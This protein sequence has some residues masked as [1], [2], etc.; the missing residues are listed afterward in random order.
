VKK[1]NIKTVED[2]WKG[3]HELSGKRRRGSGEMKE[4]P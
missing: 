2:H 3:M 1:D 4:T